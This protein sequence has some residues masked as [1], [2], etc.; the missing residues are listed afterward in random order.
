MSPRA[1]TITCRGCV[2][3]SGFCSGKKHFPVGAS[4]IA[5]DRCSSS[6]IFIQSFS[7]STNIY[8]FL[9]TTKHQTTYMP[10]KAEAVPVLKEST[11]NKTSKQF[12]WE[13]GSNQRPPS[14][15]YFLLMSHVGVPSLVPRAPRAFWFWEPGWRNLGQETMESAGGNLWC[16]WK[17]SPGWGWSAPIPLAEAC[18][19][20]HPNTYGQCPQV[21][22]PR[23][24]CACLQGSGADRREKSQF[25]V[26]LLTLCGSPEAKVCGRCNSIKGP[27][28]M[29]ENIPDGLGPITLIF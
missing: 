3:G 16:L 18:H 22:S 10:N 8:K 23:Q 5:E 25:T 27:S 14:L 26:V 15:R 28:R 19:T 1:R 7:H 6:A 13:P 4:A 21:T 11:L 29:R 17:L 24:V 12:Q 9:L 2:R 20:A